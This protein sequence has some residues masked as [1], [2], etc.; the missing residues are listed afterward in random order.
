[1]MTTN[2]ELA[3]SGTE[4]LTSKRERFVAAR[5]EGDKNRLHD[6]GTLVL[7]YDMAALERAEGGGSFF[8]RIGH[9]DTYSGVVLSKPSCDSAARIP[10]RLDVILHTDAKEDLTVAGEVRK[11]RSGATGGGRVIVS[12]AS[13][14]VLAAAKELDFP[15]C[16]RAYVDDK[17]SLHASIHTGRDHAYLVIRFRDPTNIP[18][19]LVIASL[20]ATDTVLVKELAQADDVEDAV[21][22]LGVMEV[23]A[24]GVLFSPETHAQYDALA[25]RLAARST[26]KVALEVATIV[27]SE[28]IGM[29]YRSCIDLTTMFS[30][31]EGML[32]GS[33]SQGAILC[34]P[35]VFFLPYMELRPFRVNAGAVH[36]YVYNMS[37]RTDYMTELRAGAP[38]MVVDKSGQVRRASVGRMKT[39]VRP[40]RLIEIEFA[41][42]ER[43]NVIMQDDWH[44]RI[45]SADALPLN[46]TDLKPGDQVLG[47]LAKP[48]RHVGIAVDEHILEN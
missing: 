6:R 41:T 2:N 44:V 27:R 26:T 42:G 13:V 47:H 45:F 20:Q 29:G 11:M 3:T 48:G 25:S 4:M 30:P 35:E 38:V 9:G 24:D 33:T 12:S 21:V 1:M 15:T 5:L 28:P 36:S 43:A 46:I 10:A 8:E 39:E 31:T 7:W 23:G 32:V 40:L 16:F 14:E 19:E 34:C 37:D 22:T 17:D 18:L